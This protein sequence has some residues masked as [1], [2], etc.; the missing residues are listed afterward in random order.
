MGIKEQPDTK[1][2]HCGFQ[3]LSPARAVILSRAAPNSI[4]HGFCWIIKQTVLWCHHAM[5][6]Q[7]YIEHGTTSSKYV[8][9]LVVETIYSV[10]EYT[11][12][13]LASSIKISMD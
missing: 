13:A 7:Y 2:I 12:P 8:T 9:F 6:P 11:Y 5:I 3:Q 4:V 1:A 10:L